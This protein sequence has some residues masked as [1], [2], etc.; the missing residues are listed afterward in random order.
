M[1]I[2]IYI[3]YQI[4]RIDFDDSAIEN[5]EKFNNCFISVRNRLAVK[6][7]VHHWGTDSRPSTLMLSELFLGHCVE[8]L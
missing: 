1:F 3:F 6:T 5:Q 8:I 2:K 7:H 4:L